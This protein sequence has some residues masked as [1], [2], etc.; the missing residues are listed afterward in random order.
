MHAV[1]GITGKVGGELARDAGV[2]SAAAGVRH[3]TRLSR[4]S[5]GDRQRRRGAERARPGRVLCLSTVG[6]DAVQDNLLSQRAM[7]VA[8]Q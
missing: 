2:H 5:G 4:G 6:A 7:M 3:R 1:T 8:A